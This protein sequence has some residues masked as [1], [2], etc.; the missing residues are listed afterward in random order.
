MLISI[1]FQI[2]MYLQ[3]NLNLDKIVSQRIKDKFFPYAEI[4]NCKILFKT[5]WFDQKI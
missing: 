3:V 1:L 2:I 4:Q 5:N